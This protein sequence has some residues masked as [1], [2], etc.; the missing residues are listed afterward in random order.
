MVFKL[1]NMK[2][3]RKISFG[4][5]LVLTLLNAQGLLSQTWIYFSG[6]VTKVDSDI[7]V[8]DYPVFIAINDSITTRTTFT[9]QAGYYLDSLFIDPAGVDLAITTVLDCNGVPHTEWF[10]EVDTLNIADFSICVISGD[11]FA[12][13]DF[14]VDPINQYSIQFFNLSQGNF[15]S[16]YW[17]F[18]DG[19]GSTDFNPV[20]QFNSTGTYEVCLTIQDSLGGCQDTYCSIINVG[21]SDCNADFD[22]EQDDVNTLQINFTNSS[23]GA[24]TE[25]FWDFGDTNFSEEQSPSHIYE[26]AGQYYVTLT[27][28]DSLSMCFDEV[29]KWIYVTD[30]ISCEADFTVELDTL[31]NTPRVYLFEDNSTGNPEYWLWE[32]G[33]GQL[34]FEQN[35]VHTYEESGT[36]LVCLTVSSEDGGGNCFD[37]TCQ[38][39]TTP[40]YF[41]FGGQ[42]FIGDY[43]I[44]IEENDSSNNAVAYLYRRYINKWELMDSREFWRFGYYW[45]TEKPAGEYIIRTDLLPGSLEYGNYAPVYHNNS[46]YWTGADIFVLDDNEQFTINTNLKEVAEFQ[47][48]IGHIDGHL[49]VGLDCHISITME[50]ELV[51]LLNSANQIVDYTYTDEFGGFVFSGLGFGS[52]KV[53]AEVTGNSSQVV[54]L[55]LD[56]STPSVNNIIIPVDCNSFVSTEEITI[57][58]TDLLR[59]VFPQ[60][61][62]DF[63]NVELN[64][65]ISSTVYFEI[66]NIEGRVIWSQEIQQTDGN[67]TIK[68]NVKQFNTGLYLLKISGLESQKTAVKK[69][70]IN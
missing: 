21:D 57:E 58:N 52:Y 42:V 66:I 47:T 43:P 69:I 3:I 27:I 29:S 38:T 12:F 4:L 65:G 24:I 5:L 59:N 37:T 10:Y 67:S 61:A 16:W 7:P 60:P 22:W 15:S 19:T 63:I 36:Y 70:I 49:E 39:I 6:T 56:E 13:Y 2:V 46:S 64:T 48:G 33:D 28:F 50:D 14:E 8:P 9:N 23:F 62:S 54:G 32:F 51:Y 17:D 55:Q 53:R 26:V 30:S 18:G 1:L 44:N 34:S 25:W 35:P 45:F 11:C 68:I 20:H 40:E 41:D 31:N